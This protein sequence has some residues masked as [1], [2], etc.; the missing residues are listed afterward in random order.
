MLT[1]IL[2]RK[3]TSKKKIKIKAWYMILGTGISSYKEL[4]CKT[5]QTLKEN[6]LYYAK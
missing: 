4:H 1:D 3:S 5:M 2:S 6:E